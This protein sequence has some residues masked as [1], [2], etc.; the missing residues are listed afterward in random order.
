[1]GAVHTAPMSD[2]RPRSWVNRALFAA[3]L[4]TLIALAITASHAHPFG[5][6]LL[7]AQ[8]IGM[9]IW[10]GIEVGRRLLRA[11]GWL[12]LGS[13]AVLVVVAVFAGYGF[14]MASGNLLL[15]RPALNSLSGLPRSTVGF[16]LMSLALGVFGT[17][18]FTSR[19][20]LAKARF[21]QQEALRQASEARLRLLESQLEPHMLFNTLANLRALIA[22]DPPRAIQM[23]D[24][25]NDFLRAT[26]AASRTEARGGR[27]TLR[28]EF[29]RLDDYLAL[30]AVRM[31]PRLQAQLDLPDTLAERPVPALLLQ[32]LVENAIRHGLEPSARGGTLRVAA[33]EAGGALHLSVSDDGVGSEAAPGEGFGLAQVR[34]RLQTLHGD[35]ARFEW[36]SA[37]GQGTQ[38]ELVL[39]L[40][41]E[42]RP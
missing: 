18:F 9:G 26:L 37:P 27:H 33:R 38:A 30:M 10:A 5:E 28:E 41:P 31:G 12:G 4:N 8:L 32:P 6:N 24:R 14:G 35:A 15:G 36:R 16:L 7:Y 2:H 17:Y 25:L 23:L 39:P 20:L 3:V 21:D 11:R 42:A 34:E 22:A 13:M 1:M 19:E 29:A 40:T